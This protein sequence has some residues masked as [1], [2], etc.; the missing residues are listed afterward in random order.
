MAYNENKGIRDE[1]VKNYGLDNSK[2]GWDGKNVTYDGKYFMTPTTASGGKSYAPQ[3][4]IQKAVSTYFSN[5]DIGVRTALAERGVDTSKLGY[6]N[7]IITYDGKELLKPDRVQNGVSYVSN[8]NDITNA[9]INAYKLDGKNIVKAT[10]YAASKHV[11]FNVTYANDFVWLNGQSIKPVCVDNGYAYVDAAEMDKVI[12]NAQGSMGIQDN[13]AMLEKHIDEMTPYYKKYVDLVENRKPFEYDYA[14]DPA[15]Q[16]YK[17]MYTREGD[18][19]MR[20]VMGEYAANT[21]GYINSAGITA[22]AQA[23]NYY[24]QQ[25]AD[26]IP[27][28]YESA[29]GRYNEDYLTQLKGLESIIGQK[30]DLFKTAYDINT[31]NYNRAWD[32]YVA[33]ENRDKDERNLRI[34]EDY[35]AAEAAQQKIIDDAETAQ[36]YITGGQ[37]TGYFSDEVNDWLVNYFKLTPGTKLNPFGAEIAAAKVQNDLALQYATPKTTSYSGGGGGSKTSDTKTAIKQ[38]IGTI[39]T[40][41]KSQFPYTEQLL[42]ENGGNVLNVNSNGTVEWNPAIFYSGNENA[43]DEI[44]LQVLSNSSGISDRAKEDILINLGINLGNSKFDGMY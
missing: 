22:G 36:R 18:R 28:L 35:R 6:N 39:N 11:P 5:G 9:T 31:D 37:M 20:D 43:F 30:E 24:M 17:E 23:N 10:D 19:V 14:S 27:Q 8:P 16:A 38:T 13:N 26:K 40:Y 12:E 29:Y 42:G 1:M 34:D 2:I 3:T 41:L 7:G 44:I 4:D 25:L 15:Y 21:G 32:N 33:K